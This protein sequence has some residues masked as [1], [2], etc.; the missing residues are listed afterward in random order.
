MGMLQF[1]KSNSRLLPG[2][3]RGLNFTTLCLFLDA[4]PPSTQLETKIIRS[5]RE[6]RT[7]FLLQ[8]LKSKYGLAASG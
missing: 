2:Q 7:H 6:A 4:G 1:F 8:R 5:S 3:Y